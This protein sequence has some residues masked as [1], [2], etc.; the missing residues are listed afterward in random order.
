MR[1]TVFNVMGQQIRVLVDQ[2]QEAGAYQVEWNN[3]D[4]AGQALAPGLYLYRLISGS[5]TAVG[6]MLLVK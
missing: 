3:L 4:Q 6:K 1:L 2:A 5:Q